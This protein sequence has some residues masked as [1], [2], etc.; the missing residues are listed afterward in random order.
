MGKT[1][2]REVSTGN[3]RVLLESVPLGRLAF[4]HDGL[5]VI[6]PVNFTVA[7]DAIYLRAGRNSWADRISGQPVTFEVDGYDRADRTGWSVI[8]T[9]IATLATDIETVAGQLGNDLRSWAPPP[10]DRLLRIA[11]GRIDGRLIAHPGESGTTE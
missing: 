3:C 7:E 4:V 2:L 9:G 8:V 6:R 10:R 5:P 1:E 11:I